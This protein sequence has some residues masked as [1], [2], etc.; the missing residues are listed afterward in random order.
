MTIYKSVDDSILLLCNK[1]L[2]GGISI[3][4]FQSS[5]L[6]RIAQIIS[7][8]DKQIR[9]TLYD[10]EAE[11]DGALALYYGCDEIGQINYKFLNTDEQLK[12]M[13]SPIIR[14]IQYTIKE[15]DLMKLQHQ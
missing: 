8:E 11:L 15:C 7:L 6:S 13:I 12:E 2:N 9:S 5:L 4:E 3:G 1:C 10:L 14:R